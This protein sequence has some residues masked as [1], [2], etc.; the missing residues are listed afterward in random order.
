MK[1]ITI[2]GKAQ[3]GKDTTAELLKNRLEGCKEKKV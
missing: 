3:H 2:A 1:V